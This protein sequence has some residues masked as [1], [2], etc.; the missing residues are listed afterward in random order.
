MTF[1]FAPVR[2]TPNPLYWLLAFL[3]TYWPFLVLELT[4]SG[5]PLV[6]N[7]LSSALAVTGLLLMIYARISLGRNV[8]IVPAQR[9]LVFH[10]AYRYVRHPIYAALTLSTTAALLQDYSAVNLA[11]VLIGTGLYMVK[12]LVEEQ[13]LAEDAGYREYL[14]AV[15]WRWLPGIL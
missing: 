2:I 15:R 12:S 6:A 10:G 3:A 11:V 13:F 8:G 4:N 7:W 9:N 1:R 14:A 5:R